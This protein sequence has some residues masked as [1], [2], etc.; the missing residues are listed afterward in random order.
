M[1]VAVE[2]DNKIGIVKNDIPWVVV[3][4][5]RNGVVEEKDSS[6]VVRVAVEG[7]RNCVW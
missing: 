1:R 5:S 3:G 6:I 4:G 7:N 2:G